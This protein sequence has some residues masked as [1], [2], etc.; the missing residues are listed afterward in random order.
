[1]AIRVR[2]PEQHRLELPDGDWLLVKKHLNTGEERSAL[3]RHV[4]RTRPGESPEMDFENTGLTLAVEYL[5][6]WSI[7]GPDGNPLVIRDRP[8]EVKLAALR[9]LDPE[10]SAVIVKAIEGHAETMKAERDA[11]KN[12]PAG[13]TASSATSVSVA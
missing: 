3:A 9:L 12:S 11:E 1:M 2:A 5:L 4:K 6:D 7:L 8:H 13:V 10:D